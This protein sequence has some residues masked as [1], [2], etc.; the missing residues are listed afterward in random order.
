MGY[1]LGIDLGTTFTAAA[2]WRDGRADIV[3]LGNHAATIPTMVFLREDEG[4]LIGDAAERRGLQEPARLAR[5]FKRRFGDATPI[6]LD[7]TPFSADRLMALMLRQIVADVSQR[8][9]GAPDAVAITHP[10]NWG[11]YKVDLLRQAT[12]IAG[13]DNARLVSEP[14]AAA[15]QYAST[16]R[17]DTGEVVA[18][19]D[20]GGGTFDAAV[21][22]KTATGF[23]V[24]GTP[25]GIERLGGIDF[26][27]AVFAHVRR[28][29]GEALGGVDTAS[30]PGR[31]ALARLR[32]ECVTA[33][34]SLSSD[35]DATVAVLLPN[36]QTEVRIT[37]VEFED[38][39][40]PI[41]RE[42][43]DTLKR[44]I[45]S[46]GIAD[47]DVKAILIAGGSSRIPLVSELLKAELNRP[48]VTDAHPK[49]AVAMGA[50]RLLQQSSEPTA[51]IVA[52]PPVPALPTVP[53]GAVPPPLPTVIAAGS[54]PSMP[55]PGTPRTPVA[56]PPEPAPKKSFPM[57]AKVGI[58]AVIVAALAVGGVL[59]LGGDDKKESATT[60]PSVADTTE[61]VET[62]PETSPI[63]QPDDTVLTT[64]PV[65][66]PPTDAP[67]T[68]TTDPQT[69]G[70]ENLCAGITSIVAQGD[71]WAVTYE[72]RG[73][74]PLIG[75]AGTHHMHFFYDTVKTEDAGMPGAGPWVVWDRPQAGGD[76]VFDVFHVDT[77]RDDGGTGATAICIAV[78]NSNHSI[79]Q[80]TASCVPL[81]TS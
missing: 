57:A 55:P 43:V 3:P 1:S 76:L 19:Y 20:L 11:Q 80:D 42:T 81:P 16:E 54:P 41:L 69:C 18:V 6:M 44:V 74:D 38:M 56:L 67:T 75:G 21:L 64:E 26:D 12:Q 40:R 68:S 10:A 52:V 71:V 5:E 35:S 51:P 73:F 72:V 28:I 50:V 78:A 2:V 62:T 7:R 8:Q 59:A 22:R 9:G 65:V 36:L 17:V 53:V 4:V 77:T 39:I 34:E 37:R 46:A 27:E 15:A 45:S 47:T 70:A 60:Q 24:L 25:Q 30:G 29:V 33:K 66:I 13:I 49:H 31:S 48:V 63:T 58:A 23:D 14:V 61:S 32:Q 79:Q